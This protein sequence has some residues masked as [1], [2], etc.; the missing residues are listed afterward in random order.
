MVPT[1]TASI[2]Y[3]TNNPVS[4]TTTT[5]TTDVDTIVAAIDIG[6]AIQAM[7]DRWLPRRVYGNSIN[8]SQ[9]VNVLNAAQTSVR[10]SVGG[11]LNRTS[12]TAVRGSSNMLL[13]A[14]DHLDVNS[15]TRTS[16]KNAAKVSVNSSVGTGIQNAGG[17][18]VGAS[19][20]NTIL[21]STGVSVLSST[22][23]LI[24][25]A[26]NTVLLAVT[27][28][29]ITATTKPMVYASNMEV[30]GTLTVNGTNV[31]GGGGGGGTTDALPLTGGTMTGNIVMSPSTNI[32]LTTNTG[33]LYFDGIGGGEYARSVSNKL[34]LAGTNGIDVG[35]S[36][37]KYTKLQGYVVK[38]GNN[39]ISTFPATI[40]TPSYNRY[41]F[42]SSGTD[43]VTLN[44]GQEDGQELILVYRSE[45]VAG[46]KVTITPSDGMLGGYTTITFNDVG[47]NIKLMWDGSTW[48]ILSVFNAT[49]V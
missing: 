18:I 3:A 10:G 45:T 23:N 5:D 7:D 40:N 35:D 2:A 11:T 48:I 34:S 32:G 27:G 17:V 9:N 6:D 21:N 38:G 4:A 24:R 47:D 1:R 22:N 20:K 15:S 29:T 12:L 8:G 39:V 30:F 19:V 37:T 16:I 33:Y 46:D 28:A 49:I 25:N 31:T 14:G 41:S 26:D 43:A 42:D 44:S 13:I 36:F